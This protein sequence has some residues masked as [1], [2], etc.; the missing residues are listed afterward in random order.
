[1]TIQSFAFYLAFF[2][3][4]LIYH[5]MPAKNKSSQWKWILGATV[6]WLSFLQ[7]QVLIP[8]LLTCVLTFFLG[9][10]IKQSSHRTSI[11][12]LLLGISVCLVN[13][14]FCKKINIGM[15]FGVSF[16]SLQ[17]IGY[18]FDRYRRLEF[19]ELNLPQF[20]TSTSAFYAF[21]SGPVLKT[22][23]HIQEIKN[24]HPITYRLVQL[25]L[26]RI[27]WGLLKKTIGD[28]LGDTIQ[29]Y[30]RIGAGHDILSAWTVVLAITAQYYADFSGYSDIAIGIALLL[31]IRI[32]ENFNL[33]FL[34]TNMA[35][36]WRR[37]HMS[38]SHWFQEYIFYPLCLFRPFNFLKTQLKISLA[39]VVTMLLVG[40]WHEFNFNNVVWGLYNGVLILIGT[41]TAKKM[42]H[43]HFKGKRTLA[44]GLTFFLAMVGRVLNRTPFWE[45]ATRTWKEMF[46]VL[47]TINVSSYKIYLLTMVVL[48]IICPH[49]MDWLF[50]SKLKISNKSWPIVSLSFIMLCLIIIFGFLGKPF[51]Y[52]KF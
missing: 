52:E 14:I 18:L 3:F 41:W 25:A 20:L 39:V 48:S 40:L 21:A 47:D 28:N 17:L 29:A 9:Q 51:L 33:P 22:R 5:L 7:V 8:L 50:I 36:H 16:Y 37:W 45:E 26:F 1:M 32:P 19:A 23:D 49:V 38:L 13:W 24:P 27:V 15:K 43:I 34:A 11:F 30:Y 4:F 46:Q 2:V 31:G 6:V 35:D 44:I 42:S 12:W 10:K